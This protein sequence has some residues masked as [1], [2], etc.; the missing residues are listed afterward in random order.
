MNS[1]STTPMSR[2]VS[3]WLDL[4]LL[5]RE[6]L[7][8][9]QQRRLWILRALLA[10]VQMLVVVPLYNG[11]TAVQ[12]GL[13]A[14]GGGPQLIGVIIATNL[15]AVYLLLPLTACAAIASERERQTLPLLLISR[16]SPARLVLEKFLTSLIP[17]FSM[18]T[19]SLPSLALAY[20]LGGLSPQQLTHSAAALL[21]AA[22]QVNT[23]AIFWSAVFRTSLQAFWGTLFTLLAYLIGPGML[24]LLL[25]GRF[26]GRLF[27]FTVQIHSLFMGFWEL[28][29]LASSEEA[30][31]LSLPPCAAGALFL[32]AT[33]LI[34]A[35][36][37][38]EAPLSR[39]P[40]PLKWLRD[41][42]RNLR[43]QRNSDRSETGDETADGVPPMRVPA[44]AVIAWR[45]CV[46]SGNY[47]PRLFALL[48]LFVPAAFWMLVESDLNFRPTEACIALNVILLIS[49][50]L[51]VQSV[52]ARTFG[53]ERDR[54]TLTVLLTTPVSTRELVS[55][56]LAAARRARLL[57][58]PAFLIT[59]ALSL[60]YA[61]DYRW[62]MKF[63]RW[64]VEPTSLVLIWEHLT[65]AIWV[66]LAWSLRSKT[67][68][69]SAV[70]T[71]A[72]LFGF[73]LLQWLTVFAVL[74][75]TNADLD[76]LLPVLP[77][78]AW[79]SILVDQLPAISPD[80]LWPHIVSM[81][82]SPALTGLL[83]VCLRYTILKNAGK[84]LNR[85]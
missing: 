18:M 65:L 17:V 50:V 40:R 64:M 2:A 35:R 38:S 78:I 55:Q 20:S 84:W 25:Q 34:V 13:G 45:E 59:A 3:T 75:M 12:G 66:G 80:P 19:C 68:L 53:L 29:W 62:Q 58:M 85:E 36:F 32:T 43:P 5:R 63:P 77:L 76:F 42:S 73:C 79:V 46:S 31:W 11:L 22:V 71:L 27:G 6:L 47:R 37:H 16:I 57:F 72:T 33:V 24:G 44:E 81:Y 41:L 4:P 8:G 48:V 83:L 28:P 14:F 51:V 60:W 69:R 39:L 23:A 70:G 21:L 7:E 74:E 56:K 30:F 61:D 82:L 1:H 49:G 67:T 15:V 9:A 52:A 54:E 10:T 26:Y